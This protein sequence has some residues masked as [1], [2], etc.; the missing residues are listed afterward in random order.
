MVIQQTTEKLDIKL[1]TEEKFQIPAQFVFF[2]LP[3]NNI[4]QTRTQTLDVELEKVR[5]LFG[6]FM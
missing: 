5:N 1:A 3:S 6:R 4:P 2:G